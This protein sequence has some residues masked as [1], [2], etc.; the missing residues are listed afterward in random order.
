MENKTY[1]EFYEEIKR[2]I[3]NQGRSSMISISVIDEL[4]VKFGNRLEN[5]N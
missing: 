3:R 4:I 5:E 1:K 2:V